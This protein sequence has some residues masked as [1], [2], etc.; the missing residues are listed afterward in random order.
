M[1]NKCVFLDRDGV[2]N[3]DFVDY[4]YTVEKFELLNGVDD[5]LRLL[6]ENGY[7]LIVIT[8]QSGIVK[9]IYDHKDVFIVHEHVQRLCDNLIDDIYYAPY[10]EK[11]TRSLTR[12]P[13]SLML[14]K[15]LTKHNIDAAQS[16]MVGDK[17]R[18]LIPG[19]KLG[20]NTGLVGDNAE[21]EATAKANSL[22]GI[23]QQIVR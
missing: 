18:D 15:A 21:V 8:N 7:L 14:E 11:W 1:K 6:K 12:K 22:L 13:D 9:G 23:A 10:H 16:W 19:R 4:V 17:V 2:I 5:A 20:M 3:K